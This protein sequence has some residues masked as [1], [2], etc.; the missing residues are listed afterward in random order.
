[1]S[2]TVPPPQEGEEAA[3]A[4][5]GPAV[6][7]GAYDLLRRRLA[8]D[9]TELR[10]RAAGLNEER[11]A[12]FG[13][14]AMAVVGTERIQTANTCLARDIVAVGDLLLFGYNVNL[15]LRATQPGDVFSLHTLARGEGGDYAFADLPADDPRHFL[16]DERFTHDFAELF[17]YYK[18]ARLL[19]LR[20]EHGRLLMVFQTGDTLADIRAF[21]WT[22]EGEGADAA[23]DYLDDRGER[24]YTWPDRYDFAWQPVGRSALVPAR[25]P[26]GAHIAIDDVVF[27]DLH[28]GRLVLRLEDNSERGEEVLREPV[29]HPGQALTDLVVARAR[30]GSL[31]VLRIQPYREDA[32][33]FYVVN[34]HTREAVRIDA[35]AQACQQLPEDHGIIFPG[36]YYLQQGQMR[37]FDAAALAAAGGSLDDLAF[38]H[39]VASPNGEDVLYHYHGRRDGTSLL[40]SYNLVRREV[41]NPITG[42]GYSL[43]DDG[44]MVVFRDRG[45]PG[46][47]HQMQVWATP[48]VSEVHFAGQ[49]GGDTAHDRIGNADLVRGISEALA[50]C[51][52]TE[53]DATA[54]TWHMLVASVRRTLDTYHWLAEEELGA[55][56]DP[57]GRIGETAALILE[58]FDKVLAARAEAATAEEEARASTAELVGAAEG[59]HRDAAEHISALADLRRQHGRLA[60]LAELRW[61]DE[62]AVEAMVTTVTDAIAAL[63]DRTVAHLSAD[64]AFAGYHREVE[65]MADRAQGIERVV[66]AEPVTEAIT[67]VTDDL[68]ELAD[69]VTGLDMADSVVRTQILTEVAEVLAGANRARALLTRRRD[70]LATAESAGA[71]VA[72]FAL[73]DGAV[74]ASLD[75]AATPA[76]CDEQLARLLVTIENLDQAFGHVDAHAERIAEKRDEVEQAFAQRKQRLVD[77]RA[78]VVGRIERNARRLVETIRRRSVELGDPE[79]LTAYFTAD[80]MVARVRAAAAELAEMGHTVGA[81]ELGALLEAARADAARALRDAA[82]LFSDGG[83]TVRFGPHNLTV[84]TEPAELSLVVSEDDDG[85]PFLELVITGTDW[86]EPVPDDAPELVTLRAELAGIDGAPNLATLLRQRLPSET[87]TMARAE[88]LAGTILLDALDPAGDG[89]VAELEAAAAG[90]TLAARVT[91]VAAR[92]LDEGYDRGVHDADATRILTALLDRWAAVGTNRFT[93]GSRAAGHAWFLL[94]HDEE[95]RTALVDRARTLGQLRAE[96]PTAAAITVTTSAWTA[97]A[98]AWC[99]EVGLDLPDTDQAGP[100]LLE[101]LIAHEGRS[102]TASGAAVSLVERLAAHLDAAGATTAFATALAPVLQDLTEPARNGRLLRDLTPTVGLVT[103]WLRVAASDPS[104]PG[105][106]GTPPREDELAEAAVLVLTGHHGLAGIEEVPREANTASP[107]ATVEGLLSTHPRMDGATLEVRV[108]TLPARVARHRAEVLPAHAALTRARHDLLRRR[109]AELRLADHRPKVF[110]GF[111]RNQLI[112]EVYLPIIGANLAK[113]LGA[114]GRQGDQSGLLLLISPPG[115]GKTTLV[116]YI[117]DRLGMQL[118]KV[119][120]PALGHTTASLDPAAAPDATSRA[121][122]DKITHAF[123]TGN[124]V[125]LYID[126]IQHTSSEFLQ[127]FISLCDGQRRID[128][129][130]DGEPWTYDLRGKRFAVVMAGNPYTEAGQKFQIPDML[131][132]RADTYNLGDVLSGN[133]ELFAR[134]YIENALGSN[135]TLAPLAANRQDLPHLLGAAEG[136]QLVS[137]RLTGTYRGSELDDIVAVLRH[138]R[139]VQRVLLTVNEAYIASAAQVDAYRTEPPFGL[140]GSYRNMAKL[141]ARV[142]PLMT[143]D[144]LE[145][146]IDDHYA[147]EAQTLT[148]GAEHNL[149]KLAELR[150]RMTPEQEQRWEAIRTSYVRTH[151]EEEAGDRIAD[152]IA[153]LGGHLAQVVNRDG[154]ASERIADQIATLGKALEALGARTQATGD[155]EASAALHRLTDTLIRLDSTIWNTR[156]DVP[157]QDGWRED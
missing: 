49:A 119:S 31:M 50:I 73:L 135:E 28:A 9:V 79:A 81:D 133:D 53:E 92:R 16:S 35:L 71:F 76:A 86:R 147:G 91:E 151:S 39:R 41:A 127:K 51:D 22:V 58:E 110:G 132:N 117:A 40:L 108:D 144:E 45:E 122:V 101:D 52:L 99:D 97:A 74:A 68:Q 156:G 102:L 118:V 123:R 80:P 29:E 104:L 13:S 77:E 90:G 93:A 11:A 63:A 8:A 65:A 62:A 128:A 56:A 26:V 48:Y 6:A 67:T 131:A 113:Q 87:P 78:A 129:T 3:D 20:V 36:G 109:R 84:N 54:N 75:Q 143:P 59:P 126:D 14:S 42:H 152:Q 96:D 32:E 149:L 57:L 38:E 121:E 46:R 98:Q 18:D 60:G 112:T 157:R 17:T 146:L 37:L 24:D 138:L 12:H 55:L 33:R 116:E 88:Y 139:H 85:T 105:H 124:N 1:M 70:E 15:G 111:V 142:V 141:A 140:Q 145:R 100:A 136:R 27:L 106:D 115:Y 25:P 69:V 19:D 125:L 2:D 4:G 66:D 21:R 94:G 154:G 7:A 120:G 89:S 5:Q 47:I 82:E 30:L 43:F 95:G 107:A 44:T 155:P 72:E 153:I 130:K 150:G 64:D 134:S 148:T 114:P 137:D 61:V 23:V 103:S 34:L 83:T 10:A